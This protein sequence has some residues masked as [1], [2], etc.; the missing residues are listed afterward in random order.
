MYGCSVYSEKEGFMV[1]SYF[2]YKRLTKLNNRDILVE[3]RK[4]IFT[5]V[6]NT[7]KG[8]DSFFL[9]LSIKHEKC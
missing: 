3:Q 5:F 4:A 9:C 1:E 2:L 8:E 7:D 6:I